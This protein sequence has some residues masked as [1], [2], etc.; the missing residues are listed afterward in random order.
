MKTA[1]SFTLT[2]VR[3]F[4]SIS[5]VIVVAVAVHRRVVWQMR[6]PFEQTLENRKTRCDTK[7]DEDKNMKI[8][9]INRIWRNFRTT[10][11]VWQA[12]TTLPYAIHNIHRFH[13]DILHCNTFCREPSFFSDFLFLFLAN[14]PIQEIAHARERIGMCE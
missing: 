2:F 6:A 5:G 3:V 10:I 12:S 11:T 13:Y 9:L 14:A 7:F 4:V 1:H 8:K